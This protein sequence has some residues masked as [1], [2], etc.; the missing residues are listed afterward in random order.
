MVLSFP[1]SKDAL[2]VRLAGVRSIASHSLRSDLSRTPAERL[3][4]S[5]QSLRLAPMHSDSQQLL[6]LRVGLRLSRRPHG[7]FG[8]SW[9][10]GSVLPR[11]GLRKAGL[12]G[13]GLV[14]LW[15]LRRFL[16]APRYSVAQEPCVMSHFS[17][18]ENS[19]SLRLIGLGQKVE[20][21]LR[22]R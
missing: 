18:S 12:P 6:G 16:C 21:L 19:C 9:S 14:A 13:P 2:L 1:F 7:R 5:M 11:S 20:G 8:P 22:V 4:C 3:T 17:N 10:L 15:R